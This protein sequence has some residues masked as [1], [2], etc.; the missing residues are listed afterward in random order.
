MNIVVT[1]ESFTI[2]D[3][4]I[5]IEKLDFDTRLGYIRQLEMDI[6]NARFQM[7]GRDELLKKISD[8]IDYLSSI[9][10]TYVIG[11]KEGFAYTGVQNE[12][13]LSKCKDLLYVQVFY[14]DKSKEK[15]R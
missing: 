3:V 14:K 13:V 10:A 12:A 8:D 11:F 9:N 5:D 4:A 6:P 1:K 2:D 15:V 7:Y